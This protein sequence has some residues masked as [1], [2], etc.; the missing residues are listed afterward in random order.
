MPSRQPDHEGETVPSLQLVASALLAITTVLLLVVVSRPAR[1]RRRDLRA[2]EDE[3]S[4][5][6]GETPAPLRRSA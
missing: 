6:P 3:L 1:Q 2:W 5:R 4:R